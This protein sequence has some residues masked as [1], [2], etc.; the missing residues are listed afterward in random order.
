M[1][2]LKNTLSGIFTIPATTINADAMSVRKLPDEHG[3][4]RALHPQYAD[5]FQV[6]VGDPYL[7]EHTLA[8]LSVPAEVPGSVIHPIES[9]IADEKERCKEVNIE[10]ADRCERA[11]NER[12]NRALYEGKRDEY[13]VAILQYK[14]SDEVYR[15][16]LSKYTPV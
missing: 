11:G 7:S 4:E 8:E 3:H 16:L 6:I 2:Y 1:P 12:H 9:D 13:P 5:L 14:L 10:K 15:H